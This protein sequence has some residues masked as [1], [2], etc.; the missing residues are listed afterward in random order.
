M[1][2]VAGLVVVLV[3]AATAYWLHAR[4]F[5][6]TD[7]AQIDGN[8]SNVS[9]RVSGN[10][11]AVYIIENQSVKSGDVLAELDPTEVLIGLAQAKAQVALAQAQLEAEDPSVPIT[12][13]TNQSTVASARSELA[14]SQAAVSAARSEVQQLAAQLAQASANDRTAQLEKQR[15]ERLLAQGVVSQSDFDQRAN[16]AAASAAN[17]DALRQSLAASRDRV[18]QQ[19]AQQAALQSRLTEVVS[20]APRQVETRRASV[21]MRQAALDLAN[22]QLALAEKNVSYTKIVAPVTGIVAKKSLALGDHVAPG[23]QV[24]AISQTDTLW[25]TANFRETQLP[26]MQ[27]GQLA[28]VHVDSIGLELSG[29]VE[30]IGGA[31]GSR[32]SVLP[33][34][35]A[36]GNYVKVV[37]RIP[38]RIRLDQGQT[39]LDRLRI[40]MSVE[41]K[42]TVR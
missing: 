27:P 2:F 3:L 16:A 18:L 33:P 9:P 29:A 25:V 30:S 38:V 19:Q 4:R 41:P 1:L 31:T 8:I 17:L 5:E 6:V 21:V 42:V 39:G 12:Q 20:N 34:E 7:D 10:V 11:S 13:S 24:V 14:A 15:S 26:R 35:N 28:S 22:A 32:L 37:Q 36:S 40:G 23:Q